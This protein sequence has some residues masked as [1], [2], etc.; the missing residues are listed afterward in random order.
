[1]GI[2]AL[3]P[4]ALRAQE[5]TE[6]IRI[7]SIDLIPYKDQR[8]R[9]RT[10][11]VM[12][13]NTGAKGWCRRGCRQ[14]EVE[15]AKAAVAEVS[16]TEH[17]AFWHALDSADLSTPTITALDMAAWD[18]H[19][20]REEKPAHAL[21]GTKRKQVPVYWSSHV[22]KDRE[23]FIRWARAVPHSGVKAV[24]CFADWNKENID[25]N[26]PHGGRGQMQPGPHLE[27]L[28]EVRE[29]IGPEIEMLTDIN[30][31]MTYEEALDFG[32]KVDAD[33]DLNLSYIEEPVK[34]HRDEPESLKQYQTMVKEF[35][36]G[37]SALDTQP[38]TDH[39][40]RVKWLEAR[41]LDLCRF[42]IGLCG[43]ITPALLTLEACREA[44]IPLCCHGS[45]AY[46]THVAATATAE[47]YP[48]LESFSPGDEGFRHAPETPGV[49]EV[50]LDYV[51]ENRR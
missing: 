9:D 41:A 51:M 48:W 8:G 47:E 36:T 16:P 31:G 26:R 11:T 17:G 6:P 19:G 35:E 46:N 38:G 42:D 39:R 50:E 44:G 27:L 10:L 3:A 30:F 14:N 37:I 45:N 4:R 49:A 5:D 7:T 18:L 43:G 20:R 12:T 40:L 33:E 1:M 22:K 15:R 28:R 21:I 32:R 25:P 2:A 29:I 13:D 34:I 24:K 23:D